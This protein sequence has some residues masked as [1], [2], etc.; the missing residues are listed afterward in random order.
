MIKNTIKNK[1]DEISVL[2]PNDKL[3]YIIDLAKEKN[4]TILTTEKDFL[5]IK[6]FELSGITPC[7]IN[8]NI[9]EKSKLMSSIKK[10]YD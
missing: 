4:Y 2:D 10:I 5:R 1:G 8:L 3:E 9:K 6:D 7:E